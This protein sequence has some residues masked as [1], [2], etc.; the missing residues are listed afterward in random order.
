MKTT[1]QPS[2]VRGT[3][4]TGRLLLGGAIFIFGFV[5]PVFTPLI[6]TT[7]L[8]AGWKATIAGLDDA[9]RILTD[10]VKRDLVTRRQIAMDADA[11]LLIAHNQVILDN[12]VC[13]VVDD[14]T[15]LVWD[16]GGFGGVGANVIVQD[17]VAG[18][19]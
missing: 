10:I 13:G 17:N 1:N 9:V 18:R 2:R 12:I 19:T 11:V 14:D 8:S 16:N 7:S 4:P 6:M 15:I 5:V 3:P